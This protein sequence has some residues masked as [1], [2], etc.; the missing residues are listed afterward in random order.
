MIL[1]YANLQRYPRVFLAV[2]GLKLP[3]FAALLSDVLPLYASAE[4]QRHQKQRPPALRKRAIGGGHP[5][6]LQVR[7]QLLLSLVWLRIYPTYEVLGF[8][9]GVSDSTVSRLVH[10]FM[11]LLAAAGRDQMRSVDPGRKHR[12]SLED[13][14]NRVPELTA[15]VDSF[16]Q[17]VQRPTD[18]QEQR[19]YYSGKKKAH[20]LKT[21]VVVQP[22]T[23][24]FMDVAESVREPTN[25]RTLMGESGIGER[26]PPQTV[27][28]G[29]LGYLGKA[30][31]AKE[32]GDMQELGVMQELEVATPRR[33]P[34]GKERPAEDVAYNKAFARV[35]VKVEHSIGRARRY[36]A[37]SQQDRHH[38]ELV[39]ERGQA[40]AGLVNRQILTR[41]PYLLY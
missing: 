15:L 8:L 27:M 17:R 36:Q 39:T 31:E 26:L 37:L 23:G 18:P 12:R 33:K 41:L 32:E 11:P 21:Q 35:R 3:E 28:G 1:R 20:T 24:L 38:R 10:R 2:T 7:D 4:Q 30:K 29:D 25:D 40:V 34:R 5:F 22:D 19:K 13:V 9:F 6:T 14:L 16:E